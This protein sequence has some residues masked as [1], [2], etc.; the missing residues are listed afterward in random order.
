M[1]CWKAKPSVA[2]LLFMFQ[3]TMSI[4]ASFPEGI[5][6][7]VFFGTQL[8]RFY[9][10]VCPSCCDTP[11]HP[12]NSFLLYLRSMPPIGVI[13]LIVY[14][15]VQLLVYKE[16]SQGEEGGC[17][18]IKHTFSP[19]LL[20]LHFKRLTAI[21]SHTATI[22]PSRPDARDYLFPKGCICFSA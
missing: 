10:I 19:P 4:C 3:L 8:A 18:H 20:Q 13:N 1:N 11:V 9:V 6:K 14:D 16:T 22:K 21:K 15:W 7:F 17:V 5:H 12:I 2:D